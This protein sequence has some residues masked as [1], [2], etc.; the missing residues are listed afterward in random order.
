MGNSLSVWSGGLGGT[1]R[2]PG[3]KQQEIVEIMN[4]VVDIS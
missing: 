4:E 1:P 2:N 3:A